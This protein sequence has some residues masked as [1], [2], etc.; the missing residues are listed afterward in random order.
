M[1]SNRFGAEP[2]G[3]AEASEIARRG[4][5]ASKA[6]VAEVRARVAFGNKEIVKA[7]RRGGMFV[8]IPIPRNGRSAKFAS[9]VA[10]EVCSLYREVGHKADWQMDP[11]MYADPE[12]RDFVVCIVLRL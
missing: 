3:A 4:R 6:V 1:T 8:E 10:K 5:K 7:A 11:G 9:R 2:I 12:S